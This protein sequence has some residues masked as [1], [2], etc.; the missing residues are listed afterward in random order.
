[1]KKLLFC[2]MLLIIVVPVIA[3]TGSI[4]VNISGIKNNKGV[5]QIGLYNSEA[6]FPIY[7]KN[8]KGVFSKANTSGVKHTFTDIPVG[9]YAIAVWHDENE[10]KKMNRNIFGAPKESYG[11]SNNIYGTFGPPKFE[12][13]SFKVE[14]ENEIKIQINIE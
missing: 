11:F 3:Q 9:T 7:E 5:I 10:D 14:A 6:S 13:V 4:V 2:L 1:M 8:F 12:K